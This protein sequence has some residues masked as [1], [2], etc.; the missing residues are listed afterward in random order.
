MGREADL[1]IEIFFKRSRDDT[2][3][4]RDP[5]QQRAGRDASNRLRGHNRTLGKTERNLAG[6]KLSLSGTNHNI[7]RPN[8]RFCCFE[9]RF[10]DTI[11]A[12]RS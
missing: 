2:P 4:W 7:H 12:E 10:A 9:R 3:S 1:D 6:N 11:R 8:K 5:K